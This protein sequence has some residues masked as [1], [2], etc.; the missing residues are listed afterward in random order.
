ME[1]LINKSGVIRGAL[2][3]VLFVT[4]QICGVWGALHQSGMPLESP[5]CI[6]LS[7]AGAPRDHAPSYPTPVHHSHV[8]C[9]LTCAGAFQLAAGVET[10][11]TVERPPAQNLPRASDDSTYSLPAVD[12]DFAARG[13]PSA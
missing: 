5:G 8:D 3:A 7:D 1:R 2:V 13:P 9:G 11:E 12:F 10:S 4:M 6:S